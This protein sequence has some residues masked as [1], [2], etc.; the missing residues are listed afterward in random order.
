MGMDRAMRLQF[1]KDYSTIRRAEGR[2]SDNPG[3]YRALPFCDLTTANSAQW[4]IRA[5]TW[6]HFE[7]TVLLEMERKAKRPLLILDIGAGN[8]WM[9]YRLVLR[10]HSPVAVDIFADD[11]DGLRSARH[12]PRRFPCVEADFDDL[13]FRDRTFDLAIYNASIHYATDYKRTLREARRCL[14]G[15]GSVVIMDSPV[16]K[17]AAHG[18]RMRAERHEMFERQYGFRSDAVPSIEYFDEATLD[19]L[20]SELGIRWRR[21]QPWYGVAWALRPWKARLAARR[22]P[23]CFVILVGTFGGQ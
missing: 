11:R 1:L 23:S 13:P 17:K 2:G 4:S 12:Y 22:P 16:Y 20:A 15:A 9:S 21:L 19:S 6:R 18:E 5:R 3:Y 7:N 10:A 14:R 8:G